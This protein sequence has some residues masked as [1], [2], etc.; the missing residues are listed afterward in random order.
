MA[1][2]FEQELSRRQQP[3]A[4]PA[5][6]PFMAEL[7][8]RQGQQP[9]QGTDLPRSDVPGAP[10]VSEF[11]ASMRSSPAAA[12]NPYQNPPAQQRA[13][14][15][16]QRLTQTLTP[17][18]MQQMQV[19][20][21]RN[22]QADPFVMARRTG[23][24][25]EG[26]PADLRAAYAKMPPALRNELSG[27]LV[28]SYFAKKSGGS[29]SNVPVEYSAAVDT[30]IF[31][32]PDDGKWKPLNDLGLDLED[33][34]DFM[35]YVV[36][37][38][39][40]AA[41]GAVGG[42]AATGSPFVAATAAIAADA[43]T[44]GFFRR[45]DVVDLLEQGYLPPS[46]DPNW[47]A[48]KEA[49]WSVVANMVG[50]AAGKYGR[51]IISG[52]D[53]IPI[54]VDVDRKLVDSMLKKYDQQYGE[55][56][57]NL[58]LDEKMELV[59][60]T[61]KEKAAT[62]RVRSRKETLQ[63]SSETR[64]AVLERAQENSEALQNGLGQFL[65]V[66]GRG[67]DPQV[68]RKS[69]ITADEILSSSQNIIN[70]L[71]APARAKLADYDA[72]LAAAYT[73]A[74][75]TAD[76]LLS[77]AAATERV[78][79]S[80]FNVFEAATENFKA[81]MSTE[82]D[83]IETATNGQRV[84]D[85]T[86]MKEQLATLRKRL[87]EDARFR[88]DI[89][90]EN[91]QGVTPRQEIRIGGESS[92]AAAD[93]MSEVLFGEVFRRD[94]SG[95]LLSDSARREMAQQKDFGYK[96]VNTALLELR[97]KI[98]R[99][100]QNAD[101]KTMAQLA[102]LEETLENVRDAGLKQ[103]DPELAASQQALDASYKLG[104]DTLY[105]SIGKKVASQYLAPRPNMEGVMKPSTF[106]NLFKGDAGAETVRDIRTLQDWDV[107]NSDPN[108]PVDMLGVIDNARRGVLGRLKDAMRT[109]TGM[110]GGTAEVLDEGAFNKFKRD[111]RDVLELSFSPAELD[112]MQT[113]T[114]LRR[115][116]QNQEAKVQAVKEKI[117]SF[118]WG[119]KSLADDPAKLMRLT[120]GPSGKDVNPTVVQRSRQLRQ[121]LREQGDPDG[122]LSDY[123]KLIAHDMMSNVTDGRSGII[124]PM[125]LKS[126]LEKHQE[127]LQEWYT[128]PRHNKSGV[129]L[130][131]NLNAYADI[132]MA[133][134]SRSGIAHADMDPALRALNS[135]S[136]AYVGVFTTP[137]RVL[138]AV[139]QLA[140]G[141]STSKEADFILNPRKYVK[142]QD[143]YDIM[144]SQTFRAMT[145]AGGHQ[146]IN[147]MRDDM[148]TS[149]SI[150]LQ[151]PR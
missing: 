30:M 44:S 49:G 150:E 127:L 27:F 97:R 89:L 114:S 94:T 130:V 51:K 92:D 12:S 4:A 136:R 18:E 147:M 133:L 121:A 129:D 71:E 36:A 73:E 50:G 29:I 52:V 149:E 3:A 141:A 40:M 118:P 69:G 106:D 56:M 84:F 93:E 53:D 32:D 81:R 105:R 99:M 87:A 116:L 145:L 21:E 57:P 45:Q 39:A 111:Y 95:L 86:P 76:D 140:G 6:N 26:A 33:A 25:T 100:P 77:G 117:M 67:N 48:S 134:Q 47:E 59:A 82:Y 2:P 13:L 104:S 96:E 110:S 41:G 43:T 55:T 107:I 112:K 125:K 108:N 63:L 24:Q 19:M 54:G 83:A 132:G 98:R 31:R 78:P 144:D 72:Q 66:V 60:K 70:G 28:N 35:K 91:T 16:S 137:G 64:K 14:D 131:S 146:L 88:R 15:P 101:P 139:K 143:F 8:A 119:N 115:A 61:P 7:Q 124:D 120:W 128:T 148:E 135:I 75:R 151:T 126:Y 17:A 58:T 22:A 122:L 9:Q 74:Q 37:P 62:I 34:K 109:E 102:T 113:A 85:I 1:N 103:I 123:R 10:P 138:T 79:G 80:V 65:D 68:L 5:D 23:I 20:S 42:M 46:V 90:G 38:S 142:N 11:E